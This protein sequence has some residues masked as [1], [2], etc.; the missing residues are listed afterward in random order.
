MRLFQ[1]DRVLENFR[2]IYRAVLED[3]P[4]PELPAVPELQRS[5]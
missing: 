2:S 4:L 1:P 5:W 3:R